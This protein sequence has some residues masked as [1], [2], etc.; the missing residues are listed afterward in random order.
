MT[1][2]RSWLLIFI[3][4]ASW[5]LVPASALAQPPLVVAI[6]EAPPFVFKNAEGEFEG[7]AV[8]LWRH[9]AGELGLTYEFRELPLDELLLA[10][11]SGKADVGVGALTVTVDR[12]RRLDFTHS[13]HSTGP[14]P[15]GHDCVQ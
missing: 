8:A 5:M 4:S 13:Y 6:K 11:E 10:V 1:A 3:S 7:P 14:A 15:A 9:A 12:E 2:L